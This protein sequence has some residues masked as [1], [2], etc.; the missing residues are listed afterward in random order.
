MN[1]NLYPEK[2]KELLEAYRALPKDEKR[3]LDRGLTMLSIYYACVYHGDDQFK[4]LSVE[5]KRHV[6]LAYKHLN[7]VWFDQLPAQPT[8]KVTVKVNKNFPDKLTNEMILD[9]FDMDDDALKSACA[10]RK[11]PAW[12]RKSKS[13]SIKVS[14]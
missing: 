13:L 7:L 9:A 3:A 4:F 11:R 10:G 14:A 8:G 5:E 2:R 1:E 6:L 12:G